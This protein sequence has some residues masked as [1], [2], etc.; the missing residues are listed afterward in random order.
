MMKIPKQMLF[1]MVMEGK[2]ERFDK[3]NKEWIS[4]PFEPNNEEHIHLKNMHYAQAEI[5]FVY[6]SMEIGV[7]VFR[8]IN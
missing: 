3:K 6:E 8:E 2:L 1:E 4:I 5:D 7:K